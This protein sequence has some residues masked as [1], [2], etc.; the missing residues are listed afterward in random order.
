MITRK[1]SLSDLN[2]DLPAPSPVD[3]GSAAGY[4]AAAIAV[5]TA[6]VAAAAAAL[7]VASHR[8]RHR[9]LDGQ[10]RDQGRHLI[11]KNKIS[12][13]FIRLILNW[14]N[15]SKSTVWT[16]KNHHSLDYS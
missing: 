13:E 11:R 10:S 5:R 6:A 15:Q 14:V 1:H 8:I 4:T 2:F 12:F 16:L 7:V 3:M 9:S